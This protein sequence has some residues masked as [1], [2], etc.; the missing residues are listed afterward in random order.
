MFQR[1]YYK[2]TFKHS[3]FSIR[4]E[5]DLLTV[6]R[7]F[8]NQAVFHPRE[9]AKMAR[10]GRGRPLGGGHPADADVPEHGEEEAEP[11]DN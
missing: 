10:G 5:I 4:K 2:Q 3:L 11:E 1:N 6:L 7:K 8:A 9:V